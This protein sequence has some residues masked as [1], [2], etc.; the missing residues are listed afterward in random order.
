MPVRVGVET[1]KTPAYNLT[2]IYVGSPPT[3]ELFEKGLEEGAQIA[4]AKGLSAVRHLRLSGYQGV[5]TAEWVKGI[6]VLLREQYWCTLEVPLLCAP[7][8]AKS[9]L[10]DHAKFIPMIRVKSTMMGPNFTLLVEGTE[11][12]WCGGLVELLRRQAT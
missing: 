2:T 12:S 1:S 5:G 9:G 4:L 6:L 8:I 11:A 3:K 7:V 10:C